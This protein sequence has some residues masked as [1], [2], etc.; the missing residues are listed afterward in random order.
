MAGVKL[1]KEVSVGHLLT[2]ATMVFSVFAAY[3]SI[4]K[5]LTVVENNIPLVKDDIARIEADHQRGLTYLD[6]KLI[7]IENKLDRAIMREVQ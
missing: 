2:A 7:R 5:R 6:N 3:F 4:D 1:N